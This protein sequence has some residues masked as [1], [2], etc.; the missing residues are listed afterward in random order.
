MAGIP[1]FGLGQLSK[2]PYVTAKRLV[3]LYCEQR[4]Q[5]EKSSLVAY[6]TPGLELFVNF[7]ADACRGGI[8][9]APGSLAFVVHRGTLWEV[10]AAGVTTNRGALGT[11]S[12]R[13]SMAHNGVEVM[14][15]DGVDGYIYDTGT[16]V[17]STIASA[18][19]ANPTTVTYLARRFIASFAG[20]SRFYW[21]DIDDGLTWQALNFAN[22]ESSPDELV[23]VL[24]S[25]SQIVLNGTETSEFWASSGA[26]DS[27]FSIIQ[28]T[29][30]EWGLAARWSI[31]KYDNSYACLIRN[32]MGEVMVAKMNG[33]V[34][35]KISTVDLDSIINKYANV[36]DATGYSYMLGGHPMYV[37]SF[38]AAGATWLYD[39]ATS[40]WSE[41]QSQGDTRHAGEFSFPFLGSMIVADYSAGRLYKIKPDVLT[42]NGASIPRL[43]VSETL[44]TPGQ[45][46]IDIDALRL[47]M[48]V[49]V[50]T[51]SGQGSNPQ[52]GLEVSRDNGKTWGAQM[53]TSLG[54][55]GN[56]KRVVEWRRLGTAKQFTFRLTVTDPVQVTFVA[57]AVNPEN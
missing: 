20:S 42:D 45:E 46:Y 16:N 24:A 35:Q 51:A 36:A 56:Y 15:V 22:A 52:I 17:F 3:N 6:G 50:G 48:E 28:G 39:G 40:L 53:W 23:A 8:E 7:G 55:T 4:P 30:N 54:A 57:G 31:A 19:P 32:R 1:L 29:S 49:G 12:G 10:N 43:I 14:I 9:F 11:T 33:Y 41:L 44:Q 13:V 27:A 2:S 37:L 25:S 26:L 34:P 21:S 38:P 47:S 18:L 5:G